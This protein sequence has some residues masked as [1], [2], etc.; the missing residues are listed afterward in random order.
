M[1]RA[2][3]RWLRSGL[4][5]CVGLA[6]AACTRLP[7]EEPDP[8]EV[9]EA[10]WNER[11]IGWVTYAA[12]MTRGK[13]EHRPVLLVFYTDWCPHC[14]HFSHVFHDPEVVRLAQSFVMIRVERDNN[15]ELS[16]MYDIDGEYIPRTFFLTP[17]GQVRTELCSANPA[18]RYFLDEHEPGELIMLMR[19]ALEAA[20]PRGAPAP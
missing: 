2:R 6:A 12:G 20:A 14:H 19:R 11:A 1:L 5:L 8:T 18:Y 9:S 16:A 13:D 17:E 7:P 15:R 3:R 10:D 4:A